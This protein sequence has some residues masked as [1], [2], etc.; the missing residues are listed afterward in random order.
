MHIEAHIG[1][2]FIGFP[3]H[4]FKYSQKNFLNTYVDFDF[5][6]GHCHTD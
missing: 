6:F 2:T 1:Y 3:F 5:D 4:S